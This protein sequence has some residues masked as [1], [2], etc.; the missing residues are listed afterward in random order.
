MREELI[1]KKKQKKNKTKKQ[2][3]RSWQDENLSNWFVIR[4]A[5]TTNLTT[6]KGNTNVNNVD[7][8]AVESEMTAKLDSA[9]GGMQAEINALK[10][11]APVLILSSNSPLS[12]LPLPIGQFEGTQLL[13]PQTPL[14]LP[15][16][17]PSRD[18][19]VLEVMKVSSNAP[20][21]HCWQSGEPR[22]L[23]AGP[24]VWVHNSR[25]GAFLCR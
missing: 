23:H 6:K 22:M 15:A 19:E 21:S 16:A 14:Q 3:L 5:E 11:N 4:K 20:L 12:A 24:W 9:L 10:S 13:P 1:T 18:S 25:L 8:K 2:K 7:C 17:V